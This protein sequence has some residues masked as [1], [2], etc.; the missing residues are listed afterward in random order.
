[1]SFF[2]LENELP[3]WLDGVINT[4]SGFKEIITFY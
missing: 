2:D 1:M 3:G 4:H